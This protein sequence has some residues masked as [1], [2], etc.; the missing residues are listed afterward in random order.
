MPESLDGPSSGPWPFLAG[1]GEMGKRMREHD[2]SDSPLGPPQTWPQS[3]RT[4]VAACLNSPLLGAVLWGPDLVMLYNDAYIP[5]LAD[6]HPNALGRSVAE[7]WGETWEQVAAPFREAMRA[8]RGFEQKCVEL[9]MVRHGVSETTWWD[10][11]ATPILG[12]SGDVVG[13][14][15]QGVEI[16]GQ[17][18]GERA[19]GQA[20]EELRQLNASLEAR[21]A[22]RTAALLLH[23][24]I[25]Q[26]HRSPVCAFDLDFR[27][28]A[29]N[30]AHSDEFFRIFGHRVQL[31]EVFPDLFTAE[32]APV[33]RSFMARAL[34]GESYT[35]VEEFGD[36]DLAKPYWEVSYYPLRDAE[37]RI[38]GAFHHANDIS[39][40]L[41]AQSELETAQAALRQ[42]QKMEAV[43]QLTGG[44]A[45]DFNNLLASI[46]G[47]MEL[48]RKRV[49]EGRVSDVERYVGAGLG[50]AK[51]AAALTHRLL[52]FARRQTLA[53]KPL[54]VNRLVSGMEDLA[55]RT[56]GPHIDV[57]VVAGPDL[58]TV[59]ADASQ[60]ESALLNL[61]INA[62]DAMPE[63]GRL[64]IETA[65]HAVDAGSAL[66]RELGP[67]QFVSMSV[68]DNGVGM[69]PEVAAR[70]FD[71]FFTTKPTGMGTGL[72]LSMIWG[73][74]QQSGGRALIRSEV[75]KGTTVW[76][77]LPRHEGVAPA[78]EE[79]PP[80]DGSPRAARG[81][82][83]MVLDD[84]PTLRMFVVEVMAE[85]GYQTL[86]AG[87]GAEALKI[88]NSDVRVD[89]LISD[90][91]L[92]GG[93]N[94][95]QVADAARVAR[96]DLKV[97]F[98][99]GYAESAVLSHGRLSPGMHVMTKPFE[100]DA[101]A[102]R[103][104]ELIDA[105]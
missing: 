59:E 14:F 87:D 6:R 91:G 78:P 48:V 45:H 65:N 51:R 85:L 73:F 28:I 84:E 105:P 19:R 69:S 49:G 26:S 61:C 12:E 11:S 57:E 101:L 2:W 41:R 79:A 32:Q 3:L 13:L 103:A 4:M 76:V 36:P 30:R 66:G 29:F 53:P 89:L 70:A 94:G 67:G 68:R 90:V 60:L 82:T 37:G 74:A 42:S 80:V 88:L 63:G 44:L 55:R 81:E 31:G 1:G 50:A 54:D 47:S 5:S 22:E 33:M 104:K 25:I 77:Y 40:R 16:T 18:L 97:L 8:G 10:I 102:R 96:P 43:G 52:A 100:L 23:E 46:T 20:E 21:I 75:G 34:A 83:V 64:T 71:P 17:V 35:V 92:P 95:R 62:R 86:A 38:M 24:N 7:V 93:M 15:N 27:L 9:T 39:A 98:I 56:M 72:G 99:T 58:W